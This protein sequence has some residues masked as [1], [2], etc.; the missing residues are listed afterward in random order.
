[1]TL[2]IATAPLTSHGRRFVVVLER[3]RACFARADEDAL[4]AVNGVLEECLYDL[5]REYIIAEAKL[6]EWARR[7]EP[8]EDAARA[9]FACRHDQAL[10]D[11]LSTWWRASIVDP[12]LM[13]RFT[14]EAA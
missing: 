9:M 12:A 5:T 7:G 14:E 3:A 1:M 8:F 4:R 6:G 2:P 10:L 11:V 13:Q